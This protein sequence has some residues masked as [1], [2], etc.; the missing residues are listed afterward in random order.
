LRIAALR[1]VL[2]EHGLDAALVTGPTQIGYLTSAFIF[3]HERFYALYVPAS[4]D[5]TLFG[6]ALEAGRL[7]GL[8]LPFVA[9]EDTERPRD[10][11]AR[12]VQAG[13]RLGVEFAH[14]TLGWARDLAEASGRPL[15]DLVDVG[16]LL[17]SLRV[18]KDQEEREA[19]RESARRLDRATAYARSLIRPGVTERR[20][21][22]AIEAYMREELESQVGFDAI[23]LFAERSSLPHGS[24]TDRALKDGETVLV[25]IG[26]SYKGYVSDTTRTFFL[27]EP[28]EEMRRIYAVVAEAAARGRLA[29]APGVAMGDVDRAARQHIRGA[30]YG[31]R[32]THRVG[33]GLGLEAHE[34]PFLL[35]GRPDRLEEGMCLTVEPGIYLPGVGGVR[36]EDDLLVTA[37]GGEVL[38]TYPRE[39]DVVRP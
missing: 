10:V 16:P 24:P 37:E 6:P 19:L 31:E 17:S 26:L 13:G 32:F 7:G 1:Q 4:G 35:P 39:L 14:L 11:L 2:G 38:T 27:G 36:I 15:A 28:S 30:G 29:V 22:S 33:H 3:P 5:P 23:V 8:G 21:A 18:V 25:D 20:M 34:E 9:V 12:R